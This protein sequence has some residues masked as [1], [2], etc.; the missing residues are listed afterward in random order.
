MIYTKKPDIAVIVGATGLVGSAIIKT[1]ERFPLP[2]DSLIAL[3]SSRSAGK[4]VE[5]RGETT[6]VEEFDP[7]AFRDARWVFFSGKDGLSEEYCPVAASEGAWVIDNSASFRMAADIPLVVPEVNLH[8]VGS[9]PGIIANPNCSTI[10]LA[11][12]L[13][14]LRDAFGLRRVIVS[15]YQSASGAGGDYHDQ[16]VTDSRAFLNDGEDSVTDESL[17]FNCLPAVGSLSG[18]GRFSEESKLENELRKIL[19]LA[20]LPVCATAVR[21]PIMVSHCESVV[22]ET[23]KPIDTESARGILSG[24]EGIKV[25]DD[26]VNNAFP[27]PRMAT[28]TDPVWVGRIRTAGVFENDLAF[29]VVADNLLKGAALNAVQIAQAIHDRVSES[30]T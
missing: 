13:A 3:A 4:Q 28:G 14:P 19:E 12:A 30:A 27:T 24:S 10:Q 25:L 20:D 11:V 2:V 22:I 8:A 1:L 9:R 18:N 26:P 17:A 29:W 15:T 5:F 7:A 23:E 6:L 16:L 21:V